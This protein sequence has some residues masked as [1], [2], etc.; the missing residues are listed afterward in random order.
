MPPVF[1]RNVL[2][3]SLPRCMLAVGCLAGAIGGPVACTCSSD[4]EKLEPTAKLCERRAKWTKRLR[5]KCTRCV[6]LAKAPPG[7]EA[8]DTEYSARCTK[9]QRAKLDAKSCESVFQCAAKCKPTECDCVARCFEGHADCDRIAA[10]VDSC[11][12]DVCSSHCQ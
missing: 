4:Q 12:A 3:Y 11:V 6:S 8:S 7:C 2:K 10:A 9:L 1:V 5:S